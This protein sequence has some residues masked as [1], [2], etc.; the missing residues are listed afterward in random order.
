MIFEQ[1]LNLSDNQ[2]R[3][4]NFYFIFTI[5]ELIRLHQ[6]L[7]KLITKSAESFATMY[8][9]CLLNTRKTLKLSATLG[10]E[11]FR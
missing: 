6:L 10:G 1:V 2:P 4:Y 8:E 3:Q 7:P 5:S 11:L 9:V